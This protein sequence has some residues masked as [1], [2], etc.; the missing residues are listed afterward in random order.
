MTIS[1]TAPLSAFPLA[2]SLSQLQQLGQTNP[3]AFKTVLTDI[4]N[5]LQAT[6]QQEGGREG[7]ALSNVASK[8]QQAAQTGDL[9]SLRPAH[10]HHGH[11]HRPA[12]YPQVSDQTLP[13]QTSASTQGTSPTTD[14]R[15]QVLD[16]VRQVLDQ[17]LSG[18]G[19]GAR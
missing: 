13:A 9:S 15:S 3:A 2:Q 19:T 5:K 6:A 12:G 7:Q 14:V 10:H 1:S 17:D 4:A 11:H 18:T 16:V 8:F